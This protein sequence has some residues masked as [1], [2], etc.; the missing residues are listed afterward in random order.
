[1]LGRSSLVLPAVGIHL[2]EQSATPL[3]G[4]DRGADEISVHP[5]QTRFAHDPGIKQPVGGDVELPQSLGIVHYPRGREK[6]LIIGHPI[7]LRV[8]H[9]RTVSDALDQV[10]R[11]FGVDCI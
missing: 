11:I 5:R 10:I 4:V 9:P 3:G 8:V 1:M 6:L 7:I 2:K